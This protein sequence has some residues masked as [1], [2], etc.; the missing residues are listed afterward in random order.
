VELG[1]IQVAAG[2]VDPARDTFHRA[3]IAAERSGESEIAAR[4]WIGTAE[5]AIDRGEPAVADDAFE[6]AEAW[7]DRVGDEGKLR[8]KLLY[9]RAMAMSDLGRY[10]E[11]P[12]LLD[13]ALA[14][15]RAQHDDDGAIQVT[16]GLGIVADMQGRYAEA[17]DCY[18]RVLAWRESQ[19]GPDHPDVAQALNNLGLMAADQEKYDVAIPDLERALAITERA[20]GPDNSAVG[21]ALSSLAD[22]YVGAGRYEEALARATRSLAIAEKTQGPD[23][24]AAAF[25]LAPM[26][27]ALEYLGRDAEALPLAARELA[28]REKGEAIGLE[29]DDAKVGLGI[30]LIRTRRDVV[31]GKQLLTDARA[32]Y[33]KSNKLSR[34]PDIDRTLAR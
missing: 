29:L 16:N 21:D 23:T 22:A 13:R 1:Q 28:I 20:F 10:D 14:L 5:R 33:V 18:E 26:C 9:A 27:D 19:L 11:A 4:A 12:P 31:R 24:P 15:L 25:A 6:H 30:A 32:D 7:T 34:L 17:T 8:A 3:E 2:D